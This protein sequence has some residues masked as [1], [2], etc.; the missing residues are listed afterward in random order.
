[1]PPACFLNA[2][3]P[4]PLMPAQN[5][6]YD[7]PVR[8]GEVT[9]PYGQVSKLFVGRPYLRPPRTAI[10]LLPLQRMSGS[11]ARRKSMRHTQR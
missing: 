8:R 11:G 9:P 1:M 2:P 7:S 3:T 4:L 10:Q 5:N 6:I